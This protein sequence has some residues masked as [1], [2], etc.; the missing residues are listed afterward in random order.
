[1]TRPL[2]MLLLASA[3]MM[4]AI[5]QAAETPLSV[6]P[7]FRLG[8]AG[9]LCTAQVR[10]TDPRLN[11]IFDRSYLLTCRDAAAPIGSV[12]A[13]RRAIDPAAERSA[14][15][16]GQLNC[17]PEESVE[18]DGLGAV[19]ATICRDEAA[20]LDYRRYSV[21]KGRTSYLAEG[22]AG[23][24]PA[25]R[26][27]LAS[28]VTDRSQRGTVQVATTEV[29]DPAAFARTQAGALD[30][31]GART[32]AYLRNN[33][34]RFAESAEFFESLAA[35]EGSEPTSR[36]EALA[37]Q[38]LQQS[39]LGNFAAADRLLSKA[40][41]GSP[42]GDGVLQRLMRNYRAINLLNQH[43]HDEAVMLLNV[44]MAPVAEE[45][46]TEE[47]RRG[48]I[49]PPLSVALNR[50]SASGQEVAAVTANLTQAERAAILDAQATELRG[51][52]LRQQKKLGEAE[53]QLVE[54]RGRIL[55]VRDGRVHSARWL[56]SEIEVERA[57]VAE[58]RGDRSAA[59]G[60]FDAAIAA[61]SDTFP[62]SPALLSAKARKAGFLVRSG[63]AAGG[64]TLF[65]EVVAGGTSIADSGSALRNL[66]G[67]YFD[68]LAAD[69]SATAAA[70]MFKASQLLQ[71]P[72]VAQTQA[73]LARQ[74]S[75]GNDEGSSLFRLAL[76]R[77][78]EI[79]RQD[80]EI[81]RLEGLPQRT[82]NEEAAL[83]A[84]KASLDALRA[85]QVQ[86]QAKLNDYPRYKVLASQTVELT[87]LQAALRPGE[88]YYK[89][90]VVGDAIYALTAG[91]QGATTFKLS[92]TASSMATD[93]TALRNSIVRIENG[94][95]VTEP[96]ELER[97]R[98][99]YV[100][101][102]GPVDGEVKTL[103]HLVFEPDGPMLQLPPYLLPA[104]QGGV[105]A[106]KARSAR[107]DADPFDFTGVEWLGRG[108]EVSISVSPRSFLDMRAIAPSRARQ[109]YLGLGENAVALTRPL[110]AV[111][112]ECD[113]P[114]AMWQVPISADE[115]RVAEA[116][117]GDAQSELVTGAAFNDAAL[118]K[119]NDSLD[120]YRVLHFATHGLVTAPRPD[121]PPRPALIT[122]FAPDGSDGLLSF[123][124]IF[125][126]KLDA[127]VVIL[128][129]CDTAGSATA[130]VSREAGIA[131]GGNY[132]L[133][134]LV[135][136][137]VG[138]GARSVVASHW[139]VPDDYD[140]T[141]R[142]IGG[143]VGGRPGQPLAGAL[144]DAQRELMDDPKTSHP[145]YWAAFII[146]GDGAKPLVPGNAV[147][148]A[149]IRPAGR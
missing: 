126:L 41:A 34:G 13:V 105:D 19:R 96:F 128:S 44:P 55:A 36:A 89:M 124:E 78:R 57:L 22:L 33:A 87:E 136:A 104:S 72:G 146:L 67:P 46:E 40:E 24:D 18:V 111:A 145:F 49:T 86:L 122:S 138:A 58:A 51:I 125:D 38:G 66:L 97:A 137:F 60:A 29:S 115:L 114:I 133:D 108:R 100:A 80:A 16:L 71:R 130:A 2:S 85:E 98:A 120:Q 73:I 135:R 81:K 118:L 91:Q 52:A 21:Q 9:V 63:D 84:D 12:L 149:Q 54:A 117:F 11:G 6:R 116:R 50:E 129:A 123:R 17:K 144:A 82:P 119:G 143:L 10:P 148:A 26:L 74:Y 20:G 127:E 43:R 48:L 39:N 141:K 30:P 94:E 75:G 61:L 14:L 42:R 110:T 28:V 79:V 90:M 109:A 107:A 27:A 101:L 93:V 139:P 69:S 106:Y 59:T 1:M 64:R 103:K 132:A 112:D 5:G 56:L 95:V 15:P 47:I 31:A 4:P 23:Y 62:E 92:A 45:V 121:C 76:A 102:F 142:L 70:A 53:A 77:N 68:L 35:R 140:A 25:L 37:N 147:A 113:W 88:G 65:D 134:G 99:L 3:A 32:E 8:D 7:S 131:T 83:I